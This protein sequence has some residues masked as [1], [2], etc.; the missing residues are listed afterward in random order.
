MDVFALP[1]CFQGLGLW[2]WS[3]HQLGGRISARHGV[4]RTRVPCGFRPL[5][6]E[7]QMI[8]I[9][10][11]A[12]VSMLILPTSGIYYAEYVFLSSKWTIIRF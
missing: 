10:H 7:M 5:N 9:E 3:S 2:S 11:V 4:R 12:Y 6:S 1:F 8:E